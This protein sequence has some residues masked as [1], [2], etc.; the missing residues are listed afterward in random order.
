MRLDIGLL[1][2][3]IFPGGMLV[4][5][6]G[7]P[8]IQNYSA[9]STQFP[10]PLGLGPTFT[11]LTA[12]FAEFFCGI[13]VVLGLSTRLATLPIIGT[14]LTAA[15]VVHAADPWS[16]KEFAMLYAIPFIA[17]FFTGPG[18]FSLDGLI[19]LRRFSRP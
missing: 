16:K 1:F 5:A 4:L 2:L 8:K 9:M 7:L 10:D 15:I 19:K 18:A 14:L 3:R 13:L 11:L 17:L 12:I 6:H